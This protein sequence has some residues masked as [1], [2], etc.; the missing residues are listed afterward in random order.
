MA[1]T[2]LTT[3]VRHIRRLVGSSEIQDRSDGQLVHDF[4][5]GQDE[6]AFSALVDRHGAMV[7]RVCRHVLQHTEDAEDAFQATFLVLARKAGSLQRSQ[8]VAGWLRGVAYR[9][10]LQARRNAARRQTR[11]ARTQSRPSVNPSTEVAWREVQLILHEEIERLPEKYRTPFVFCC[12]EGQSRMDVAR[13]LGL[14]E[15]TVWSRLS[16]ARRQLQSRLARR[17]IELGAALAAVSLMENATAAAVPALLVSSTV[18]MATTAGH[19]IPGAS[20]EVVVLVNVALKSTTAARVSIALAVLVATGMIGVGWWAGQAPFLQFGEA[21]SAA[22]SSQHEPTPGQAV[23]EKPISPIDA[24]GDALPDGALCRLGTIRFNHG[25]DLRRLGYTPDGKTVISASRQLVRLW[26]AATGAE[27]AQFPQPGRYVSD[28]TI[29]M[30]DSNT[31]VFLNEE[32]DGDFARWWDLS[33]RKEI[34][35]LK[36]PVKRKVFSIYYV[37]ALS[38]DGTFAAIHV[39]TPADL[40]IFDLKTG[41]ELHKFPEGGKNIRAVVFAGNDRLVTADAKNMIEVREARTGKLI[42]R[43][44]HETP[45]DFLTVSPDGRRLAS[46]EQHGRDEGNASHR[47]VIYLWDLATCR[48]EHAL[49]P[50]SKHSY[51]NAVFSPDGTVLLTSSYGDDRSL[52]TV[53]QT[54]TGR[55]LREMPGA[56]M[57]M[58]FSPDGKRLAEGSWD[59]KFENW[60]L[61]TGR[62]SSSEDS[63]Q[64][65]AT[66]ACLSPTGDRIITI[67]PW[68]IS[69]WDSTNAKRLDSF[70]LSPDPYWDRAS[71]TPHGQLVLSFVRDG[72]AYQAV[73]WDTVGRR[74]R[75]T[76]PTPSQPVPGQTV[77]SADGS[78]L[79][80]APTVQDHLVR[81]WNVHTG[82]QVQVVNPGKAWRYFFSGDKKAILLAGPKITAVELATGKQLYAWRM[83]PLK[84]A[85]QVTTVAAGGPAFNEDDRTAWRALALSPDSRTIAAIHWT[86]APGQKSGEDRIALYDLATGKL[87]RHW[88]DPGRQ[89][90]MYEALT[91]SDDGRLLASSDQHAIH[92]WEVA[93]GGK[94]H[95]FRGHR[96]E[97]ASLGFDRDSRRLV[98][99][100]FDTTVL[101][102]D[103]TGR[104]RHGKL[105][106][107]S[108]SAEDLEARWRDLA[109]LDAVKAHHAVWELTAAGDQAVDHLNRHLHAVPHVDPKHID[110]LISDLDSSAFTV[111]QAAYAE[112]KKLDILA[113]KA[114]KKSL[115]TKPPLERR[116][117]IESLLLDMQAPMP[118]ELLQ[119]L[120]AVG[121]LEH[122]ASRPAQQVIDSLAQGAGEAYLTREAR[123]ALDRLRREQ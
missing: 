22:I 67:G 60:D 94:I 23:A 5:A 107:A 36:L 28:T 92:V 122:V 106:L 78:L 73:V 50:A 33:Q 2:Q 53:W 27:L 87:L 47:G 96:A 80:T 95:T 38:S 88:N 35:K 100:S 115:Q 58:A 43:L 79:A 14:K 15:G 7:L 61:G 31:L 57:C 10:A 52:L 34:R 59:G 85:R 49:R 90:N 105:P 104:L 44:A 11:E 77:F 17:G 20:T 99:A 116:R 54:S 108:L 63:R 119:A 68:S 82:R 91:F 51:I 83:E 32:G 29:T 109:D 66:A 4:H 123:L 84:S 120:R 101:C 48:K 39:H 121:V 1:D 40:R 13:Q 89:A 112:L 55:K 46:F 103:L 25:A 9:I 71:H 62:S 74:K 113:E 3:V 75:F 98:S 16:N 64:S 72:E 37:N 70:P 41:S 24:Y 69:T 18:R 6:R 12:L 117:R 65:H 8:S 42:R 45:V 118:A 21:G 111:R 81:V 76:V 110:G 86:W 56:G 93:T 102:W 30:P 26:D 19:A 97:I 114:L